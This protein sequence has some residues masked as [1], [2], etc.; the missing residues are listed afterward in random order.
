[1][2][3]VIDHDQRRRDIIEV[4]RGLIIQGGIEAAT[5]REIAAEA[6]FANGALKHYFPG[7]DDIIQ[8]TYEL[9]LAQMSEVVRLAVEGKRGLAALRGISE[10]SLPLDAERT[11]AARVLLSFW[12]RAASN[13]HLHEIYVDHLVIWRKALAQFITEGRADGDILSNTPD[14]QLIQEL[15][16][17]NVG[18]TLMS[19]INPEQNTPALQQ[20]QLDGFF[21]RLG[22]P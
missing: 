21:E 7:K 3:K 18:A 16:T 22:R 12:E 15:V 6:G 8:G 2:P 9:S 14:E 5:M 11:T 10:A 13:D 20:A 17:M 1:M 19:V 4:T